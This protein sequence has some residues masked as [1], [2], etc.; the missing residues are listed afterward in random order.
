[1]YI[2]LDQLKLVNDAFGHSFGDQLL[3]QVSK[4]FAECIPSRDTLARLGS[5][6][7]CIILEQCSTEQA[8]RIA[9][10]ISDR[11]DDLRF[12]HDGQRFRIGT[13]V[14]LAPIV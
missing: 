10:D 7:F 13:S 2:D 9:Q 6:E 11:M 3:Q 1:M 5:G 14:G 12:I 4:I 8:G